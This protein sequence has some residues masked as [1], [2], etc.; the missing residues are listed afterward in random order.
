M[1]II[2]I[3]KIAVATRKL[4]GAIWDVVD[5]LP[6]PQSWGEVTLVFRVDVLYVFMSST[7]WHR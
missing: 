3:E 7:T 1:K 4:L 2:V 6:D 5:I